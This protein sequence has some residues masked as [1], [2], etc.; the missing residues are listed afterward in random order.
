M[1]LPALTCAA[2][3][4]AWASPLWSQTDVTGTRS[5][6]DSADV[7]VLDHD[8]SGLGETVRVF[9][10]DRQVYRAELNASDVV[11]EIRGVLRSIRPPQVYP[12]LFSQTPSGTTLL[13]IHPEEDAVYEIRLIVIAGNMLPARLRLY[14]DVDAS[15]RRLNVLASR[16]WEIG[17]ELAGGWHSG[18]V[19]SGTAPLISSPAEDGRD[20][21]ACFTARARALASRFSA[22]V[23][24]LSHQSQ[25]GARSILWVYSEPRFRILGSA[26][27][28][29]SGWEVGPLVR[30]GIGMISAS[31]ETPVIVAPGL[32]IARSITG[33][34]SGRW[35]LQASY[36]RAFY[37]N[38]IRDSE[39]EP[40]TPKGHR[41]SFGV[42]W[43][44]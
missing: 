18:F 22:C 6:Q 35:S 8:F 16:P 21:E 30:V 7:L 17:V 9:L 38:F 13:E 40:A 36:S 15:A 3:L 39:E 5:D 31:R 19:Q 26:G 20:V 12:F 37:K 10:Q 27:T 34:K 25:R 33:S 2:W 11:L 42:G 23:L 41:V 32:Y 4:L 28:G 24:G 43:Y 44:R 14:R 1:N 29:R